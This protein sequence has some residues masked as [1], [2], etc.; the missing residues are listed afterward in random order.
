[1]GHYEIADT[2]HTFALSRRE[3]ARALPTTTLD[4]RGR[5]E[6]RARAAPAVSRAKSKKHTSIVTTGSP[7]QPG[8]PRAMVL[9]VSFVLSPVIGLCCHRHRRNY[10]RQLDASVETSGP[11]DFAVREACAFVFRAA[12]RPPHPAPRP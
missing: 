2:Q 5:R 7:E 11:H 10:F 3:C 6:C 8:I 12:S 4:K 1:M 9:T